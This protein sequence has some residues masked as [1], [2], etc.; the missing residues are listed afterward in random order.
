[1]GEEKTALPVE[2]LLNALIGDSSSDLAD[3]D[4]PGYF[5]YVFNPETGVLHV[6]YEHP[7]GEDSED[8]E[9]SEEQAPPHAPVSYRFQLI[10]PVEEPPPSRWAA[11]AVGLLQ[12]EVNDWEELWPS[13]G[14]VLTGVAERTSNDVTLGVVARRVLAEAARTAKDGD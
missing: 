9:D 11:D 4:N 10:G 1:M 8:S 6:H 3:G 13:V 14:K 2:A 7:D 5:R 12:D